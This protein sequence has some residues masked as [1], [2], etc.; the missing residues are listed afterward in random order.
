MIEIRSLF[1]AHLTVS[2][3]DRSVAFYR[4]VLELPLAQVFP[5]RRGLFLDWCEGRIDA[6][7]LGDRNGPAENEPARRV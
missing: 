5:E 3:L 6:R 7:A 1:E 4:D 2:E